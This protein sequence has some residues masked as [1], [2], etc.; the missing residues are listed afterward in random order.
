MI[1]RRMAI[2]ALA[3]AWITL[4]CSGCTTSPVAGVTGTSQLQPGTYSGTLTA[5]VTADGTSQNTTV[6]FTATINEDGTPVLEGTPLVRGAE[7]QTTQQGV[8]STVT[9]S[10]A[11]AGAGTFTVESNV[12][13]SQGTTTLTGTETATY[14]QVTDTEIAYSESGRVDVTSGGS[15][16]TADVT[17]EGTLSR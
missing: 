16:V 4:A 10:R 2:V 8:S 15:T 7:I 17:A 12:T 13:G 9:V 1:R 6:T 14:R 3:G 5:T 11:T